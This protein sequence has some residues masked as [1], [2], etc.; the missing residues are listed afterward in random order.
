M[1]WFTELPGR[2]RYSRVSTGVPQHRG[3]EDDEALN[4]YPRL[5]FAGSYALGEEKVVEVRT[6]PTSS[7]LGLSGEV[8]ERQEPTELELTVAELTEPKRTEVFHVREAAEE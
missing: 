1:V 3:D 8:L 6:E 2:R 7:F 4:G 5:L